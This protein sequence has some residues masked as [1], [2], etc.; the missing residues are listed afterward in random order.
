MDVMLTKRVSL[1]LEG[2][3]YGFG[4]DEIDIFVGDDLVESA[5]IDNDALLVRARLSV[6]L[7]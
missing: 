2:L 4:S 6:H 7:Q 3:Y 5:D 1:G